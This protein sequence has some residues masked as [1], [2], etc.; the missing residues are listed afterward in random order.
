ML[1]YRNAK[2]ARVGV[3]G[4]VLGMLVSRPGTAARA[5]HPLGHVHSGTTPSSPR[6]A[7]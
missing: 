4:V 3:M 1:K 7:A 5:N 6:P 2:L